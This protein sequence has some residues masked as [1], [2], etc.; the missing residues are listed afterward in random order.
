MSI[1]N[2]EE[3]QRFSSFLDQVDRD[4][5]PF[6]SIHASNAG[7]Y[8]GT[9]TAADLRSWNASTSTSNGGGGG[10]GG[11][12]VGPGPTGMLYQ[13]Y[14]HPHS[15]QQQRPPVQPHYP[16]PSGHAHAHL[17][18]SHSSSTPT[19]P[20]F[21]PPPLPSHFSSSSFHG[22]EQQPHL[23]SKEKQDKMAQETARLSEWMRSKG[24][25]SPTSASTPELGRSTK[26]KNR[27]DDADVEHEGQPYKR[28]K[29][30]SS[31]QPPPPPPP[32]TRD[33][34]Q[35]RTM[36]RMRE[37]EIRAGY[38]LAL[39]MP[40]PANPG[41]GGGGSSGSSASGGRSVGEREVRP[42]PAPIPVVVQ[43]N[44]ARPTPPPPR[45]TPPEARKRKAAAPKP[46][47]PPA[48]TPKTVKD[49][50]ASS[51]PS[52]TTLNPAPETTPLNIPPS[53]TMHS[54]QPRKSADARPAPPAPTPSISAPS[55]TKNGL[56]TP[57]QK[58]ANHILSEQKRRAAIRNGYEGLCSVVPALRNA[59]AEF[60]DRKGA[61]GGG[62]GA[63]TGRGKKGA[64]TGGIEVGGE[65]VD[66]RAGPKSEAVVLS[67]T[68]ERVRELLA[69]RQGLL[70]RLSDAYVVADQKHATVTPGE[71]IWD[72]QWKE[73]EDPALAAAGDGDAD[74]EEDE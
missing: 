49:D 33:F 32:P 22:V 27:M 16:Q 23:Y 20:T 7:L 48:T 21:T 25:V 5:D 58:K 53:L 34:E 43:A 69:Q 57:S 2:P 45:P 71:R 15:Y 62:S 41:G 47:P 39:P 55:T 60:E 38:G 56:L 40:G 31:S 36:L 24:L 74:W 61:A 10:G 70:Q 54:R 14:A 13:P 50:P 8:Y 17:V 18:S 37:A 44:G 4:T 6:A 11:G 68:V 9:P 26:G 30:F 67:K 51:P 3:S 72:E 64:L 35:E 59:V 1:L 73:E 42:L 29:S 65:K 63:K 12:V 52:S 66:G 28:S 19:L 46:K